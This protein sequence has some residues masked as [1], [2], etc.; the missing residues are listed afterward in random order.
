MNKYETKKQ[1]S[2]QINGITIN[3]AH[4]ERIEHDYESFHL[5]LR[6]DISDELYDEYCEQFK[7]VYPEI[8]DITGSLMW[9]PFTENTKFIIEY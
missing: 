1:K 5:I 3:P 8:L 9:Y 6:E 2:M 4:I 7:S